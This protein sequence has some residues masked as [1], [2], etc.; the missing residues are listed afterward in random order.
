L[1]KALLTVLLA[2][3][4]ML[5]MITAATFVALSAYDDAHEAA[6]HRQSRWN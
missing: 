3:A 2:L 5:G 4:G 1:R 6:S